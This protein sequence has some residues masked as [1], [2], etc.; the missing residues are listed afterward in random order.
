[1]TNIDQ[2]KIQQDHGTRQ[3]YDWEKCWLLLKQKWTSY[4]PFD[5]NIQDIL[6]ENISAKRVTFFY[7]LHVRMIF[8]I[9][10]HQ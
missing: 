1:M 2:E 9:I 8:R 6:L 5:I 10:T 7:S 4:N 3:G